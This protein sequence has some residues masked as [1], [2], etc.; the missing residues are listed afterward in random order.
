MA[1]QTDIGVGTDAAHR[2]SPLQRALHW[3]M[4]ALILTLIPAG[5]AMTNMGDGALKNATYELHKSF[6]IIVFVLAVIRVAVRV[7][8]GAPPEEASLTP[9]Q[10]KASTLV[11][12]LLYGLIVIVPL[13]GYVG[14]S[15]CC[16]PVNLFWTV[17]VPINLPGGFETAKLV[18]VVHKVGAI[19][20]AVLVIGHIG[21]ALMHAF[22]YRDGV[23]RR[24]WG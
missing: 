4:A 11:H 24:M 2:Y 6:G 3:T 23:M 14:T 17:P 16:A 20:M 8:R 22:V 15:M 13:A 10:R 21:A 12:R 7:G 19:A 18:F 1:V 9:F 5:I